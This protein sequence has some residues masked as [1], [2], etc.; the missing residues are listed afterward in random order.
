MGNIAHVPTK[1][2]QSTAFLSAG[3]VTLLLCAARPA[4]AEIDLSRDPFAAQDI[5]LISTCIDAATSWE[6]GRDCPNITYKVCVGR[7]YGNVSHAAQAGCNSRERDLWLHLYSLDALQIEA[8]TVLK[9]Q[10]MRAV[11]DNRIHAHDSF[12]QFDSA[13]QEYRKVQC[14][15]E[16]AHY[17][18]GNAKMTDQPICEIR[19]IADGVLKLRALRAKMSVNMFP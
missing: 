4:H 16:V 1:N 12:Q 17:G 15:M 2:K 19:L 5:A 9:D 10:Q 8:W 18:A 11:G 3:I 6:T 14:Q 13:W 7:I